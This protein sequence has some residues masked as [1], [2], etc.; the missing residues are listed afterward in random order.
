MIIAHG[1]E[2]KHITLYSPAQSPSLESILEEK[3][4]QQNKSVLSINQVFNLREEEENEDLMDLFI[5][6]PDILE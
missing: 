3:E 6:E 2:R 1:D 4:H 5:S